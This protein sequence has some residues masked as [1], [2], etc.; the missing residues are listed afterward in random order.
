MKAIK[1]FKIQWILNG[2]NKEERQNAID[3]LPTTMG[4]KVS[5]DF[6]ASKI[7]NILKKK[8]GYDVETF[9]FVEFRIAENIEQLLQIC[10]SDPS[11][12]EKNMFTPS[13]K[14]SQVGKRA[15]EGLKGNV[16][17]RVRLENNGTPETDMPKILDEVM[18]GLENLSGLDWEKDGYNKIMSKVLKNIRDRHEGTTNTI[19]SGFEEVEEEED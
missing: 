6:K 8:F 16:L 4:S 17:W 5:D 15:V 7:P 11:D 12:K 14:L 13:G 19:M 2:L 3:N 10:V 9:S 18:L 1:I